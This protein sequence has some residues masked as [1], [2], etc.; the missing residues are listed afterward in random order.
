MSWDAVEYEGT[1]SYVT[2]Y[3]LDLVQ[4][5]DAKAGER[6]L[7][8]GCGTG[9]L[10]QEIASRGAKV[11]GI[12]SSPEM[13]A[14]ARQNYPQL[15]FRLVD[16]VE[17][18]AEEAFDAVFSNAVLHWIKRPE[19]VVAAIAGALKAGGRLV[20][21]FGGKGNIASIVQ[22]VGE[23]PWYFPSV[24]EYAALLE[25]HGF[26][27][28]FA[29]LFDRP[30]KVAGEA[31][32]REWLDMFYKPRLSAEKVDEVERVLRPRLFRKGDWFMDYRRLRVVAVLEGPAAG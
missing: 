14:Q 9:R 16:A 19:A 24:G 23:N 12:D 15:K 5:L 31:G 1:H 11:F 17:F 13:I 4:L 22:A 29:Q 28:C 2:D 6:V 3:G 20:V 7:D 18:C 32:L 27:V 30:T 21:E 26:E 8:L 10:T 25:Q